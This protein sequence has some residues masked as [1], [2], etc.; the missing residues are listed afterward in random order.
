M[1]RLFLVLVL[2]N[3]VEDGQ[4]HQVF[5]NFRVVRQVKQGLMDFVCQSRV[6][7]F[8]LEKQLWHDLLFVH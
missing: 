1:T 6:A 4:A 3:A 8:R 5:A 2:L 7:L